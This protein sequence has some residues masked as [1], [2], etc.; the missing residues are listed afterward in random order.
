[1]KHVAIAVIVVLLF[2]S[3]ISAQTPIPPQPSITGSAIPDAAAWRIWLNMKGEV[4]GNH[5][6]GFTT[7]IAKPEFTCGGCSN[8]AGRARNLCDEIV[9][10][11]YKG[12]RQNRR[13]GRQ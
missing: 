13:S 11:D 4:P 2:A 3:H 8:I 6:E 12:E 10:T 1:M 7:Y 5:T 9:S